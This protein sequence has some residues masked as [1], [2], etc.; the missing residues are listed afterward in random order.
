LLYVELPKPEERVRILEALLRKTP[1][2]LELA[3]IARI[4]EFCKDFSGADLSSLLRKAAQHCLRQGREVVY[5]ADFEA[6]ARN[7]KPSVGDV[8]RY[9]KLRAQFETKL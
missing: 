5:M 6:A 8:K 2:P 4:E 7:I 1:H 3:S 9:E